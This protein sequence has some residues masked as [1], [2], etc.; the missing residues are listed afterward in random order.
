MFQH[1]YCEVSVMFKAK[2]VAVV[3]A[4]L[5]AILVCPL[6]WAEKL[7]VIDVG[8]TRLFIPAPDGFVAFP[9]EARLHYFEEILVPENT[10]LLALFIWKADLPEIVAGHA[11][12]L[13]GDW[14]AYVHADKRRPAL[15]WTPDK[16]KQAKIQIRNQDIDT[17]P[18][19][20]VS[21]ADGQSPP[22]LNPALKI[23]DV[24]VAGIAEDSGDALSYVEI[25]RAT[26]V[27]YV[28]A[29]ST[30]FWLNSRVIVLTID[31][32]Y[33]SHTDYEKLVQL[34]KDWLTAIRAANNTTSGPSTTNEGR[35]TDTPTHR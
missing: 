24:G 9:D 32:P 8:G 31:A 28:L 10:T 27:D 22:A 20:F 6:C 3:G 21:N 4:V 34:T 17:K 11:D 23:G 15:E 25:L 18:K 1:G 12:F 26:N 30:V 2:R 19:A 14:L 35:V 29:S 16:L 13:D 5:L 7:T 33:D